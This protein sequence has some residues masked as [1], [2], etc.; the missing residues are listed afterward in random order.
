MLSHPFSLLPDSSCVVVQLQKGQHVFCR[1]EPVHSIFVLISGQVQMQKITKEGQMVV[2]HQVQEQESFAEAALFSDQYHCDCVC[3]SNVSI[4][5]ISKPAVLKAMSTDSSFAN[6]LVQM[7][8]YQVQHYRQ[9]LK[10][11]S[12]YSAKD[13]VLAALSSNTPY[14]KITDL[15][16]SIGLSHEACY[17][18]LSS[19]VKD[20]KLKKL[21]RGK[22]VLK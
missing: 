4:M 18:A 17:R 10:I 21:G 3:L 15:A 22:Y 7:L 13:R 20:G 1:S 19:L 12:I 8:S 11:S 16:A 9:R 14:L 6:A 2:I 5:K